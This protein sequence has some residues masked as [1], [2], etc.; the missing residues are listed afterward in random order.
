M[1]LEAK[2]PTGTKTGRVLALRVDLYRL[3]NPY[4]GAHQ[5]VQRCARSRLG[6][7]PSA[8]PPSASSPRSNEHVHDK[9]SAS[10]HRVISD[11]AVRRG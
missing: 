8:R 1:K 6:R 4:D 3:S 10:T 11:H 5:V 7:E 2:A 9:R